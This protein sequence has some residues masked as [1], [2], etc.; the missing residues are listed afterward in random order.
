MFWKR[1]TCVLFLILGQP[2][3]LPPFY[4]QSLSAAVTGMPAKDNAEI[5]NIGGDNS[6]SVHH[7]PAACIGLAKKFI[8]L[9]PHYLMENPN[10]LFGQPNS[11]LAIGAPKLLPICWDCMLSKNFCIYYLQT[12]TTAL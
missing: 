10:E 8:W 6:A 1:L 11:M 4:F 3:T 2:H 12:L 9:F 7:I 5:K